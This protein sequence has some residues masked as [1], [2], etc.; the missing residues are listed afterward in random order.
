MA[1]QMPS[2]FSVL[3]SRFGKHAPDITLSLVAM[4]LAIRLVYDKYDYEDKEKALSR[5]EELMNEKMAEALKERDDLKAE[6]D[7]LRSAGTS[8][9]SWL[10]G[11]S[12]GKKEQNPKA[13]P[14]A[15][16]AT[17]KKSVMI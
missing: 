5:R 3:R 4:G 7:A 9:S 1:Q 2:F 15:E 8:R 16:S 6:L 13:T 14:P 11:G 17:S 12:K 10:G